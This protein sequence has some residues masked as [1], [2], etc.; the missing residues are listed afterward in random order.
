MFFSA[1]LS[2][3]LINRDL[4]GHPLASRMCGL[5]IDGTSTATG[6]YGHPPPTPT[7]VTNVYYILYTIYL[8]GI[9]VAAHHYCAYDST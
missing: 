7:L 5:Y 3:R 1:S 4:K 2:P 6:T 9:A 8:T